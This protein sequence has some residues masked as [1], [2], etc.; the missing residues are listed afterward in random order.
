VER[1]DHD[2]R[3]R[4]W[5]PDLRTHTTGGGETGGDGKVEQ[6]GPQIGAQFRRRWPAHGDPAAAAAAARGA[7]RGACSSSTG[8]RP[9]RPD[10]RA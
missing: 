2:E 3:R 1:P 10:A 7:R 8:V 6:R 4:R 9:T 5:V